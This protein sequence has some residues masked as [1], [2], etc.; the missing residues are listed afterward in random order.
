MLFLKISL[1]ESQGQQLQALVYFTSASWGV[2]NGTVWSE[3]EAPTFPSTMN[4]KG[5]A[6]VVPLLGEL[7]FAAAAL[8]GLNTQQ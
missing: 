4:W 3:A 7:G 1:E 5:G 2:W 8:P 6:Q